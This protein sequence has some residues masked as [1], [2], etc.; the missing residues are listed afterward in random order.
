M[1]LLFP[2]LLGAE[3]IA[4]YVSVLNVLR[5]GRQLTG[6]LNTY[7]RKFLEE[8][9]SAPF[10]AGDWAVMSQHIRAMRNAYFGAMPDETSNDWQKRMRLHGLLSLGILLLFVGTLILG[11]IINQG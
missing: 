8:T 3:A 7:H 1:E 10:W 4:F 11:A 5:S 6:Y 2:Y 9:L